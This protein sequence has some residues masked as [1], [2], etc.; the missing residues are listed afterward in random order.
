V[1]LITTGTKSPTAYFELSGIRNK[2]K[3]V[4]NPF[5]VFRQYDDRTVVEIVEDPTE[6]LKLPMKTKVMAQWP[7]KKRSEFVRFTVGQLRKHIED[8][9]KHAC[10]VI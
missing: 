5:I 1:K 7:G 8:N 9:P 2:K 10:Q 4:Q 6:L 3:L